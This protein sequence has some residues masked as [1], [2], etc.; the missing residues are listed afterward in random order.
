MDLNRNVFTM[1]A[2][3]LSKFTEQSGDVGQCLT[4]LQ[5]CNFAC[6]EAKCIDFAAKHGVPKLSETV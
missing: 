1:V 6:I 5:T 4:L 3:G 2:F